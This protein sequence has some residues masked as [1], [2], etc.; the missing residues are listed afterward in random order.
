LAK[1]LQQRGLQADI[2]EDRVRE[3]VQY[4]IERYSTEGLLDSVHVVYVQA[5]NTVPTKAYSGDLKPPAWFDRVYKLALCRVNC[6]LVGPRGCGKTTTGKLLADTLDLPFYSLSLNA[7]VDEGI[8]HGWLRPSQ[9]GFWFEYARAQFVKAYQEGGVVLLD[10][11]DAADPNTLI[12]AHEA[13][14]NGH[15]SIPLMGEDAGALERHPDFVVIACANTH[16]HGADRVYVG[17]NQLDGATLDRFAIGT[18]EV[19]YDE[20][21]EAQ[22][23]DSRSVEYGQRLRA[24]CRA[25]SGWNRDVSTRNIAD[26]H[27]L[28]KHLAPEEA[29][30]GYFSSWTDHDCARVGAV[31]D[32][33]KQTVVL[34]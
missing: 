16:G 1:G 31:R 29:W 24:R 5:G 33:K 28:L 8:I 19:D 18:I 10:E 17:R 21:L 15:W 30:Y 34:E 32:R 3:L 9:K 20:D 23:Y 14:S 12:V 13:L 27:S 25:Q 7:G 11:I 26:A 6:L 22:C 2:S 4:E